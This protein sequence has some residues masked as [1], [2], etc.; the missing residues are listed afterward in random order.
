MT[1]E[2]RADLVLA[3]ARV[4][5]VN[6][7]STDQTLA[8][9]ERV[10]HTLGLRAQI[11][12]RWGELQLQAQDL[13]AQDNDARLIGAVPADPT[14]VAMGRVASTMRAIEDL[15]DGRLA[16]AAAKEAIQ[17]IS[18]APPA[19][20]WLF[21]LAAAA[22]AV[23]LAVIFG[24]EHLAAAALI[25]VSAAAGA[26][27]RRSLAHYSANV[28]VQPFGAAL[29]AGVIGA[30]AV[31]YQLSSSLRLV[32]VCPCMVLVPG[33]PVLN[34]ALDLINGR[35]HLGAA[36]MIYAGLVVVAIST[37]LLLGLALLGVSLPVDQASRAVPLWLDTI[38]AGVAVAA[39]SVFFS[40]P[41][42]MLAWPVTVGMLAHALRWWL[43]AVFGSSAAIG[44]LV[45]CLIVGIIL[46]PV[47]RH[48]QMPFAAIGFASVVSMIPGVFLFRM[49]SG[50]IQLGDGSHTTLPLI[51]ATIADGVTATT[52]IL[53]MS[54]GLIVPKI[55]IDRLS[56]RS[57][58][59]RP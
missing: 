7:Q 47:A 40:T 59:A 39:Y 54:I 24:V 19:P 27:L 14:G 43:L 12:P 1:L 41:L 38:A 57:N 3:V 8:S 28:F 15:G 30:L 10:A 35:V 18:Q 21:T 51:G 49:A 50:L 55:A 31:R 48:W 13:Q 45:A 16:A 58:R 11:I 34:G 17:A 5:Y 44:A 29:L 56:D 46:T 52:I 53:A 20:A 32:A 6:G 2:D 33:P 37:G 4:L 36:R 22:G 9:A 23:A 25:F 26:I 42:H